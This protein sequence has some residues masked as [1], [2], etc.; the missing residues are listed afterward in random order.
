MNNGNRIKNTKNTKCTIPLQVLKRSNQHHKQNKISVTHVSLKDPS[1]FSQ[2]NSHRPGNLDHK[3]AP[4]V[5]PAAGQ[6]PPMEPFTPYAVGLDDFGRRYLAISGK[7][8]QPVVLCLDDIGTRGIQLMTRA[9]AGLLTPASRNKFVARCEEV[10]KKE[11][12]FKVLSLIGFDASGEH[13]AL[14]NTIVGKSGAAQAYMSLDSRIPGRQI[15]Q[16]K[17]AGTLKGWQQIAPYA[18]GN[19][20]FLFLL[21]LP[22]IGPVNALLGH[23]NSSYML[24][25]RAGTG[26]TALGAIVSSVYGW[27]DPA[28]S[29]SRLGFGFSL[30]RT[31]NQLEVALASRR[32]TFG[33]ID[34]TA[35]QGGELRAMATCIKEMAF[36]LEDG[37]SKGRLMESDGPLDFQSPVLITSNHSLQNLSGHLPQPLERQDYDRMIDITVPD[38]PSGVFANLHGFENLAALI[39]EISAIATQHHGVAG[40]RFIRW[41]L[42]RHATDP[43]ALATECAQHEVKFENNLKRIPTLPTTT[44]LLR[45]IR[46][47]A[48]VYAAGIL[49]QQAGVLPLKWSE[50][51]Q[52][53]LSCCRDYLRDHA[54]TP[55]SLPQSPLQALKQFISEHGGQLPTFSSQLTAGE[56]TGTGAYA[57]PVGDMLLTVAKFNSVVGGSSYGKRLRRDLDSQG[58]IGNTRNGNG[59]TRKV[60]RYHVGPNKDLVELVQIKLERL[61]AL[62]P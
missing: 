53:V 1:P 52:A 35:L 36:K 21:C 10:A 24:S 32:H 29:T 30:N 33:F 31:V 55:I 62:G 61:A 51:G 41:L 17:T 2:E 12:S 14:G 23:V 42:D 16:F 57:G 28:N 59:P 48:R 58:A 26:K 39:G 37:L 45:V 43:I 6:I 7:D 4:K 19:P 11:P 20:I 40:R 18:S 54:A 22:F 56:I 5:R 8:Q 49:A 50:I 38:R 15:Q 47:F 25:G 46:S 13:F 60:V 27:G 44:G 3:M 9:G 34:E